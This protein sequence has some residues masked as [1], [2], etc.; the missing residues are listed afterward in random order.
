MI[1]LSGIPGDQVRGEVEQHFSM[2]NHFQSSGKK[3]GNRPLYGSTRTHQKTDCMVAILT[4]WRG[5]D[6]ALKF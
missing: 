3:N 6:I 1:S 2:E 4:V 5:R